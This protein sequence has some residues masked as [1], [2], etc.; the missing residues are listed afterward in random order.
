MGLKIVLYT[1]YQN[2]IKFNLTAMDPMG[3]EENQFT[4]LGAWG[5]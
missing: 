5:K 1:E 3:S 4:P 2:V